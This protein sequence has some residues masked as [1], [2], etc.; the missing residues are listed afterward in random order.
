MGYKRGFVEPT[1]R[2]LSQYRHAVSGIDP[3]D[4]LDRYDAKNVSVMKSSAGDQLLHSCLI[5]RV[6]PHH[7]NGDSHP[8]A[9]L[10]MEQKLY[11]CFS[12]G[13]GDLFWLLQKMEDC[14]AEGLIPILSELVTDVVKTKEDFLSE[15]EGL[16][17]SEERVTNIPTYVTRVLEPWLMIHP[18]MTDVRGI[19][20]EV[21]IDHW[22]GYD[23]RETRIVLPHF[24]EGKLVGWQKRRLDH[25]AFPMTPYVD[26][27]PGPKYQN[28]PNFPK[29]ETLYQSTNLGHDEVLIME[30]VVSVLRAETL[31]E[32]GSVNFNLGKCAATFG[33]KISDTQLEYLRQFRKVTLWMD[34]DLAGVGAALRLA[35]NLERFCQ[36][37]IVNESLFRG[38][39]ADLSPEEVGQAL[40]TRESS[41]FGVLR[42][43][44]RFRVLQEEVRREASL[45]R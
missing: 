4:V 35:K 6:D 44:E 42:L 32:E 39:L 20:E 8:S 10:H 24:W 23:E 45:G 1:G 27:R 16:L 11:H 40:E 21:L 7:T 9:T 30:G 18:Y 34:N 19:S 22:V 36:V 17:K 2:V 33:A 29:N 41:I 13:G 15:I 25:P 38:D 37:E 43:E 12:Y 28:S 14:D 3:Y 31:A 26:G 5:D